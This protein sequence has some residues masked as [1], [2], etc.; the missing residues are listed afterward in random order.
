MVVILA[1]I[2]FAVGGD[3]TKTD[4]PITLGFVAPLT[5]DAASLG[6]NAK[7]A[8]EV[9]VSE[10]NAAGG[11]NGRQINVIYED[12]KC[13]GTDANNAGNK[14][15]NVDKVPAIIGGL[16]SP[17]TLAIAPLANDSKTVLLSACS[18]APKVTEA[19]DYVFRDYPSDTYQGAYAANYIKDTLGKSKVA[20]LYVKNDWG[21]GIS[22]VFKE[23]FT[24]MG[25]AIVAEEGHEMS[26]HD[27][28]SQLTKIKAAKPDAVYFLSFT[29]TAIAGLKQAKELGL[30]IPMFGGDGWDDPRL[31]SEVGVAGEGA[32]YTAVAAARNNVI[33]AKLLAKTGSEEV[34]TCSPTAY[35]AAYILAE[36]IK[37]AGT[38]GEA[39]KNELYKIE[40]KGGVSADVV[41][42]DANGDPMT[43]NYVVK[44]ARDG[45]AVAQ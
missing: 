22:Q 14:L 43:A 26:T 31:W 3:G 19:G 18:S 11:V 7:A 24:E 35:D 39:I 27:V 12:G 8:V 44:V 32:M 33:K 20:I 28:R 34:L 21:V 16:C 10:I 23:K 40:Y 42:F 15:I 4:G 25:G 6:L 2:F 1:V 5:G 41:K 9:A 29:D 13:T 36:A 45:K 17:E 30:S 37:V 38:N